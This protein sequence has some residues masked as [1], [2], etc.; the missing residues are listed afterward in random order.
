MQPFKFF[1]KKR[2]FSDWMDMMDD[3]HLGGILPQDPFQDF[4]KRFFRD[5]T[6]GRDFT[7][8]SM[9]TATASFHVREI[10]IRDG[11]T[12]GHI[13]CYPIEGNYRISYT[14]A[15]YQHDVLL[16]ERLVDRNNH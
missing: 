6:Q 14:L 12:H 11:I 5:Y 10:F 9:R 1:Q 7:Y 8:Q 16:V 4:A 3:Y 15:K 2:V 13:D